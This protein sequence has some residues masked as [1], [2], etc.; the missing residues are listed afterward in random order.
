[1]PAG[2]LRL[3]VAAVIV[4]LL[5]RAAVGA[6]RNRRLS[7]AVWRGIGLGHVAGGFGLL[8]VVATLGGFLLSL[9]P[10][11][12]GLGSLLDFTGNAVFAPLNEAAVRTTAAAPSGPNWR[13]A[14]LAS[15]F[16]L[17]LLLL[18]PW[19]AFIEEELFRAG[20]EVASGPREAWAA[21]KFG[22]VHLV[23]LVPVGA[24]LA[25]AVAGFAY[26]RVYRYAYRNSD[27]AIGAPWVVVR[28][29]R[30][31]RQARAALERIRDRR[32]GGGDADRGDDPATT[33]PGPAPTSTDTA[34]PATDGTPATGLSV[35][36]APTPRGPSARSRQAAAV[37][38]STLWHTSF[39]SLV[40]VLL[41]IAVVYDAVLG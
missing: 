35:A 12:F 20:L 1:M 31:A 40:V 10:L 11:S 16:L 8:V 2:A 29:Y 41:W 5:V 33:P 26:G 21:L 4:A 27:E 24:T 36:T 3:V 15:V 28:A 19:L 25:I 38:A 6:W 34:R 22:L 9:T 13:L 7:L 32:S 37:Y 23:M 14:G 30:P 17:F 18:L 39:N